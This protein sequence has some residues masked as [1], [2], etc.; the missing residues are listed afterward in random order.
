MIVTRWEDTQMPRD[1]ERRMWRQLKGAFGVQK[2]VFVE[3][4]DDMAVAL[5][6]LPSTTSR[7]FLEPTGKNDLSAIPYGDIALILGNTQMHNR[8][9]AQ[10]HDTYRIQTPNGTDLYG[11]NA[12]A[13]ALA[14]RHGQ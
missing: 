13:I 3:N 1:L 4:D 12:A 8:K 7:V 14:L 2:L 9:F 11:T 5:D 10:P 6:A